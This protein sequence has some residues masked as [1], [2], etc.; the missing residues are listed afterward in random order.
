M[1]TKRRELTF[2]AL[3][4]LRKDRVVPGSLKFDES[5]SRRR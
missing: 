2:P 5:Q 4:G 1:E 3:Q